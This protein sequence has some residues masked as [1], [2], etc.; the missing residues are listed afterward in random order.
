MMKNE[1]LMLVDQI[2]AT[3]NQ[4]MPASD[5]AQMAIYDAWN[6]VLHDLGYAETKAAFLNMSMWA[7]FMPRPGALRRAT[8]DSRPDTPK[9][10]EPLVAW[11]KW[12]TVLKEVNSGMAPS[13]KVSEALKLTLSRIGE[14][15]HSMH[16]NGDRDAFC[17][18]YSTV[19]Q[20][21]TNSIYRVPEIV[22]QQKAGN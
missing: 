8:I 11:G 19:V 17:A 18:T 5:D 2:Y 1:L 14:A 12:M 15:A 9:F 10:D 21:L 6:E 20:E 4:K 13:V 22:T 7:E 16:T 3:Y